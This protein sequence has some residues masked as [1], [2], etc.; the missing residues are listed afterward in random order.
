[1]LQWHGTSQVSGTTSYT[2]T[3]TTTAIP[4]SADTP[5]SIP[6][7]PIPDTAVPALADTPAGGVAAVPSPPAPTPEIALPSLA[8][9]PSVA[10]APAFLLPGAVDRVAR[11]P[12]TS[13]WYEHQW[14]EQT[15]TPCLLDP[16]T[17][18]SEWLDPLVCTVHNQNDCLDWHVVLGVLLCAVLAPILH[19]IVAYRAYLVSMKANAQIVKPDFLV[20][21][22][23]SIDYSCTCR[24]TLICCTQVNVLWPWPSIQHDLRC[25]LSIVV[26]EQ[27]ALP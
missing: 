9:V 1:V 21:M 14:D 27:E 24:S 17:D 11:G 20:I 19:A 18:S 13:T 16:L 7:V 8:S 5:Q 12:L 4:E 6:S 23:E 3:T 22:P 26:S 2:T 15:S 10:K 25:T